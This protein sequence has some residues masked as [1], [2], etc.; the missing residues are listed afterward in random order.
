MCPKGSACTPDLFDS[1]IKSRVGLA[2][3][4][5]Y[6]KNKARDQRLRAY[7]FNAWFGV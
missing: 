4:L 1:Q 3:R 7:S 5:T 6:P 2:L